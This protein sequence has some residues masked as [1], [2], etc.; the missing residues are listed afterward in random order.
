MHG[1][2]AWGA[3]QYRLLGVHLQKALI[4]TMAS[5]AAISLLWTFVEP[6]LLAAGQEPEI[7]AGAARYLLLSI[8]ALLAAGAFECCKRYL[9][10]QVRARGR[11]A[12]C[13]ECCTMAC[14]CLLAARKEL[15]GPARRAAV[16]HAPRVSRPTT[17][18][19]V[20]PVT[21][22]SCIAVALAPLFNWLLIFK[23][24]LGL[25]GAVLATILT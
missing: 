17:Q 19:V 9:M 7:V 25:D 5:C 3:R 22:V 16:A 14:C 6:L 21:G 2:Q 12:C 20:R 24:G 1:P 10:A 13:V 15:S 23:A 18:G 4:T 11:A 8:P